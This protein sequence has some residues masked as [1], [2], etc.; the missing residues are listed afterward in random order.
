MSG[1]ETPEAVDAALR[2]LRH[3]DRSAAE[4]D[5][6]LEQKGYDETQRADALAT[7]ERTG[8]IDDRRFAESRAAVLA[9][10]GAGDA[11]VRHDLAR[12]GI[13]DDLVADAIASLEP[14]SAR[15]LRIAERRG[16]TAKT[17]RYLSGKGFSQE[18]IVALVATGLEDE[19]G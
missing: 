9:E 2:T 13:D 5:Q 15:A 17:A 16:F 19:L 4:L 12:A 8:L 10:R 18:S 6:R 11:L 3:R 14:E 1:P 7:L